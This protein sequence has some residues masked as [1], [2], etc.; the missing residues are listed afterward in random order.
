MEINERRK[1]PIKEHTW[2]TT[3]DLSQDQINAQER[4]DYSMPQKAH[5]AAEIFLYAVP[6]QGWT[7]LPND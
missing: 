4:L 6:T 7:S 2:S 5:Q 3:D 1:Y